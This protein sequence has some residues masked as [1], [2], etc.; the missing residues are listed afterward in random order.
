MSSILPVTW[1]RARVACRIIDVIDSTWDLCL[2][3]AFSWMQKL[4]VSRMNRVGT[5]MA[6]A[7]LFRQ[8]TSSDASILKYDNLHKYGALHHHS[9]LLRLYNRSGLRNA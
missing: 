6:L 1:T 7:S 2:K 3:N 4:G 8:S 5:Q 9:L